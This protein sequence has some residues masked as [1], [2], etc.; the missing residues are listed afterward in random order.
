MIKAEDNKVMKK[1][2]GSNQSKMVV[3]KIRQNPS[4]IVLKR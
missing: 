4:V 3:A 2:V 1:M